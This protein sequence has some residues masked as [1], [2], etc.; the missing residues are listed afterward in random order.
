MKSRKRELISSQIGPLKQVFEEQ[1]LFHTQTYQIPSESSI[2]LL[3]K[4][5]SEF[6]TQ[7]PPSSLTIFYYGGHGYRGEETGKLKL[8]AKVKPYTQG[9][10]SIFYQDILNILKHLPG[11][12]LLILDTCYAGGATYHHKLRQRIELLAA[13]A[14]NQMTPSPQQKGSF[15]PVLAEKLSLLLTENP[16]G[17]LV[18]DLFVALDYDDDLKR[19]PRWYMQS[20][21]DYGRIFLCPLAPR[22]AELTEA[23]L[24][25][26]LS[27]AEPPDT[28]VLHDIATGLRFIPHVKKISIG[29]L[30]APE[31]TI[32]GLRKMINVAHMFRWWARRAQRTLE[33]KKG[34]SLERGGSLAVHDWCQAASFKLG[35]DEEMVSVRIKGLFPSPRPEEP[36][37]AQL[38]VNEPLPRVLLDRQDVLHSATTISN[39]SSSCSNLYPLLADASDT[40]SNAS[41]CYSNLFSRSSQAGETTPTSSVGVNTGSPVEELSQLATQ[42]EKEKKKRRRRPRKKKRTEQIPA[43]SGSPIYLYT[44]GF[45]VTA[46]ILLLLFLCT[47]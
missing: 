23:T 32:K 19:K 9:D 27:I 41:S 4:M 35:S 2:Q 18:S 25:L 44:V 40:A 14:H 15:T 33:A 31:E 7:N 47:S 46:V 17:F 39:A 26:C 13:T 12:L 42:Q 38:P 45:S 10:S 43:T 21:K 3:N 6:V 36:G 34:N 8:A 20:E 24:H 29:D 28:R 30:N 16:H 37:A 22:P 11:D 1:F 5:L